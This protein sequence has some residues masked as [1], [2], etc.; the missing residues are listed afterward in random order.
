MVRSPVAASWAEN[1]ESGGT[2]RARRLLPPRRQVAAQRL[3]PGMEIF[4]LLRAFLELEER[5]L[6]DLLVGQRQAEPGRELVQVGLAHLLLL[7][8]DVLPLAGLAHAVALD[9]LRQDDG[10]LA[11]VVLGGV[12]GGVD[13]ERVVAAPGERPDLVVRPAGDHGGELGILAEEMLADISTVL[14]LEVLVLA[15]DDFFHPLQ[16]DAGRVGR[17]QLVPAGA[18]QRLDHVPAGAAEDS[19]QLL[20]DLAVAAHRPVEPLQVAVDHEHQIVEMLAAA[21]RDR[22]QALGLVALAV[23]QER[24]DLAVG[25]VRQPAAVQIFEESRLVDRHQRPEAHRHGRELPVVR[26]QPRVGIGTK[27]AAVDL[28][29]EPQ[30]P[31]LAEPPFQEAPRID[32]GRAVPLDVDQVAAVTF[33]RRVPEMHEAGVVEQ[34]RGL[35]AGDVPAQLRALLVGAQ[36]DRQRIPADVAPDPVLDR[37]VAR[38]RRLA[39]GWDG[40]EIGRVRRIRH[41]RPLAPRLVHQLA[42]QIMRPLD[43]LERQN[44][45]QTL[46]PLARLD[47]IAV[48][49]TVHLALPLV[50]CL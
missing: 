13:L 37:A 46:P 40:V 3:A 6:G 16:Q 39:V 5:D 10:G 23:A 27:S 45:L 47:G 38:M 35:E 34:G 25:R 43:P 24:P 7:M 29:A 31:L 18:P 21:E 8:G 44:Q 11:L 26:H 1:A 19:L 17:D 15:I 36:H 12:V 22:T 28:L 32:P 42:Q 33:R 14:G 30:E 50:P 41:L 2:S 20:D 48:R 49:D 9:R 4:E